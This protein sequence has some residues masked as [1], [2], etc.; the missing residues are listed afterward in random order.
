MLNGSS[1]LLTGGTGSFGHAF[2]QHLIE[3]TT[4]HKLIVFSRDELKQY[5]MAQK[6]PQSKYPFLRYFIGDV[7]DLERLNQAMRGV[8]Y[9]VHA[10]AMKQV[11]TAEYN[12]FECI[13]TNILGAQN[14]IA[15]SISHKVKRVIALSTDKAANPVNLYG[16]TKLASDKLFIAGNHMSGDGGP[17]FGVVRYGNVVGSRGSVIP[18]YRKLIKDGVNKFPVTDA[19]MTRFWI[20]LNQGVSFLISCFG[21]M[22]GGEVFVPKIP[23]MNIID[24]AKT[25]KPD[26]EI[27]L[28]GIRAGE[29]LH[30]VM[31]P[32]DES[33]NT[34]EFDSH[35]VIQ[36]C[37]NWWDENAYKSRT[38]G[39][40][41]TDG[42][43]YSSETNPERLSP[44]QLQDI[45]FAPEN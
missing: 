29:K 38:G 34:L 15:A 4:P 1:I 24:L 8:D 13:K 27:D 42:F 35:F 17:R 30:E 33:R 23:S 39:K 2:V 45:V 10:A 43:E 20:T 26:C 31:V 7:R 40:P 5:E 22:E 18:F 14:V 6:F 19:R 3:N 12:P 11:P 36:P 21:R 41:V 32:K 37:F 16:A 28:I 44:A 25:L 9:V